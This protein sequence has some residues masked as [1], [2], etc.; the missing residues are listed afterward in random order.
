[1]TA[2]FRTRL[3]AVP[4]GPVSGLVASGGSYSISATWTNP[5][6]ADFA[7]PE[8]ELVDPETGTVSR[9]PILNS[10]RTACTWRIKGDA[11]RTVRVRA[12]DVNGNLSET[13]EATATSDPDSN[14]TP[15]FP[16]AAT[17]TSVPTTANVRFTKP[18][19]VDLAALSY[20]LRPA[21]QPDSAAVVSGVMSGW[22]LRSV[23]TQTVALP[24]PTQTYD[25]YLYATDLNGNR[26]VQVVTGVHAGPDPSAR[27]SMPGDVVVTSPS[28]NVI[29]VA[30]RLSPWSAPVTGWVA[31]ATSDDGTVR[32]VQ[33]PGA[34]TS[35]LFGDLDGRRSWSVRLHGVNDVGDGAWSLSQSVVVGD[36]TAPL[37]VAALTS[38]PVY[39][40]ATL[41]WVNPSAFD[42]AKVVVLRRDR[43]TGATTT[44]YT[45]AA[46]SVRV[47][48]LVPG[49]S[50]GFE[51]RSYDR[52]GNVSFPA[53]LR[54]TQTNLSQTAASSVRYGS[55]VR[56]AGGLYLSGQ[57]LGGRAVSLFAQPVCSSTWR[58]VAT[59]ATASTGYYAFSVKPSANVRYRVGYSGAGAVGGS[60]S[61]VRT[62]T[63]APVLSNHASRTSVSRGSSVTLSTTVSPNHARRVV[64]LQRWTGRAWVTVTR[65]YLSSR[66]S[67]AVTL[68]LT[69]RGYASY[70]WYLPAHAD[71]AA[72][73]SASVRLHV[74]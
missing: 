23:I 30:W 70:R 20:A 35:L 43:A 52:L 45:G 60:Y 71:H 66:S 13:V 12:K 21:G 15:T 31:T 46:T 57:R 11:T 48:G 19:A 17:W 8:P 51:V 33:Y 6:D 54:V 59:A 32:T 39:D 65:R 16:D 27:P 55:A 38:T 63:V 49:R 44:L 62:V 14:G 67:A 29:R 26:G 22:A 41:R 69:T 1:V 18:G 10:T 56:V 42:F 2:A 50:Y 47:T 53:V 64:T 61:A 40:T 36:T 7:G 34:A 72:A 5:T 25:L 68:R 28:D 74:Y 73:V 4:P 24:D 37:P 9:C 3:D 58:R